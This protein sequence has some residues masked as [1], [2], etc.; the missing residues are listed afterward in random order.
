MPVVRG[1]YIFCCQMIT[2]LQVS[3]LLSR[4][5]N[6]NSSIPHKQELGE[7]LPLA[8][9]LAYTQQAQDL[10]LQ[11]ATVISTQNSGQVT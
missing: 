9:Q 4:A 3:L 5:L 10:C 2:R 7:E 1:F 6:I 11:P 8:S